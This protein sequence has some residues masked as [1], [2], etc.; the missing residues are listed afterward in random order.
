MKIPFNKVYLTNSEIAYIK[1]ALE[2]GHICGDGF[3]TKSVEFLIEERVQTEKVFMTTSGTHALEMA[4]MMIGLNPGDEVIM[5]SFTFPSTANAVMLRGAIP[6]FCEVEESHLSIDPN[7]ILKKIT[8]KTKAIIAVHYA[9]ISCDM[10]R[11]MKIAGDHK[12]FLIE[13]AAQGFNS[14]YRNRYLGSMGHLGCF[15]FHA[16][17]NYT[18]GEGGALL[19]ND[20]RLVKTAETIRNM[21]TNQSEFLRKEIDKY[22]WVGIGSKYVP[23]DILM[24]FLYAQL[25]EIDHITEKR[26]FIYDYYSY[27]LKK[28]VDQG[29]FQIPLIP[30]DCRSNYH[31]FYL[32]FSHP[33]M[34]DQVLD[35]LNMKEVEGVIHFVPLHSSPMGQKLG[36]RR[37]DLPFTE[38]VGNS[39][40]RLPVYNSITEE[41]LDYVVKTLADI[42]ERKLNAGK[43]I[44]CYSSL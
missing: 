18:G 13:D 5:P 34:R 42:L 35:E 39:L 12:L 29:I 17:K 26:R 23:S 19:V 24:A 44:R 33:Q 4:A 6:V 7:D 16:T 40:L 41:E 32:L 9:G 22:S 2:S 28:Y 3:Y 14:Q 43:L 27:H 10:E 20:K 37:E 30:A 8:R 15:S 36:Y 1:T 11:I 38:Q 31:L 21:G 25:Q